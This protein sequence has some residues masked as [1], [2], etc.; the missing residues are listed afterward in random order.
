M[1]L[2]FRLERPC[3]ATNRKI[4][5]VFTFTAGSGECR[6]DAGAGAQ[7]TGSRPTWGK[8]A[9]LRGRWE[10]RKSYKVW[11]SAM[12]PFKTWRV[13]MLRI[14]PEGFGKRCTVQW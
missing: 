11:R 12:R 1:D 4:F 6:R 8:S 3:W 2:K 14:G 7:M 10:A 13:G 5:E 9:P